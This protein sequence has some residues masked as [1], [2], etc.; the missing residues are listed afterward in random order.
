VNRR[1]AFPVEAI[2]ATASDDTGTRLSAHIASLAATSVSATG[3]WACGSTTDGTGD[4]YV[5]A[6]VCS[7]HNDNYGDYSHLYLQ[8]HAGLVTY[9]SLNYDR[10]WSGD[11]D[12][13]LGYYNYYSNT[14]TTGTGALVPYGP[15]VQVGLSV[16]SAGTIDGIYVTVPIGST[17]TTRYDN[18]LMCGVD[19]F[20]WA[21]LAW[22]SEYH[23]VMTSRFGVVVAGSWP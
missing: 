10:V 7:G 8:Q 9:T 17:S 2:D 18:P 15:A 4:R 22:C 21:S 12:N 23:D 3:Q 6:Y 20:S 5:Y 13:I 19:T 11:P 16:M 14:I 1:W